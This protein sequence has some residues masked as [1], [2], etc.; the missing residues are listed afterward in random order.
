MA[1][2]VAQAHAPKGPIKT[3][4]ANGKRARGGDPMGEAHPMGGQCSAH[5]KQT[6]NRCRQSA[7]QG[8]TVCH[9]HG[10][11][12]PQVEAK[13]K[14]RLRALFPKSVLVLDRLLGREEF[15]TVQLGAARFVAEQEVGKATER[16]K[17]DLSGE[18]MHV[19]RWGGV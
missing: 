16:V 6:G 13:A 4:R 10:G 2:I 15:P 11:A 1:K 8:G 5:S 14:E 19:L 9:Y 7:I 12:A 17:S 18:V 3:K